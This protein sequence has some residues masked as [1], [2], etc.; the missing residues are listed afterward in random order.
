MQ[1]L[2]LTTAGLFGTSAIILGAFGA[3]AFKKILP[4]DKLSSFEVGVR[5]QMYSALAL[6]II[7]Y[8]N[9]FLLASQRWAFYGIAIGTL[10]FAVSIYFLA[11]ANYWKA[12][13]RF[14]GP[15]T[16]LGGLLMVI[17]WIALIVSFY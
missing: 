14:L 4:E 12:N 5:Y 15:I 6:L 9:D 7:G 11:F 16:P 3:H 13:L 2:V 17:G 8:N 10:L 1:T